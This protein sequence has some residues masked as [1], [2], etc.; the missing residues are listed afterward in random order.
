MSDDKQ[1]GG[2]IIKE[3]TELRDWHIE[4]SAVKAKDEVRA[5]HIKSSYL[6]H[7]AMAVIT[8]QNEILAQNAEPFTDP[9]RENKHAR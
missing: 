7:A 5:F 6:V 3:L 1:Q 2:D 8:R 4:A 9:N